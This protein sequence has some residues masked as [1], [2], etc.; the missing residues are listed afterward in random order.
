MAAVTAQGRAAATSLP[1]RLL[2]W[3][4]RAA[5]VPLWT[6]SYGSTLASRASSTTTRLTTT[7]RRRRR[8]EVATWG[9]AAAAA[10]AGGVGSSARPDVALQG[11][12]H[13][14]GV[15]G[16]DNEGV[17]EEN[18][19][20]EKRGAASY[21]A[22]YKYR[23]TVAYDGTEYYGFQLQGKQPT[24]QGCLERALTTAAREPR[25]VLRVMG[26]GRTDSG[27][28]AKG[29]VVHFST[30]T[31][32]DTWKLLNNLN[33]LLPLDI[34]VRDLV[35]V[36]PDFHARYSPVSKTYH[37][38]IHT[39]PVADPF[40]HKYSLHYRARLDAEAMRAGASVF[41]GSHDFS[42]F[43]NTNPDRNAPWRNPV[44]HILRCDIVDIEDGIRVEVQGRSFLYR[45]VRNMVG[46]LL[47]VGRGQLQPEAVTNLLQ[48]GNRQLAPPACVHSSGLSG[49]SHG[50]I[51]DNVFSLHEETKESVAAARYTLRSLGYN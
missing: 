30:N 6:R 25:E 28:H 38:N 50:D 12:K 32:V 19:E 9:Q 24:V 18:L 48:L 40:T 21:R 47:Q 45:M 39:H 16:E 4:S 44:R 7:R 27:V 2:S 13:S 41:V 8:A 26:A 46:T 29:Q 22:R 11:R 1:P 15:E 42:T 10:A 35:A 51:M 14:E 36:H 31:P 37:Y 3:S 20:Q 34:R 43:A 49:G 17:G 23:V 33:G 5:L